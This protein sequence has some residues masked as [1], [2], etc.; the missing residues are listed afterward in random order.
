MVAFAGALGFAVA[1]AVVEIVDAH[2]VALT[3]C[4]SLWPRLPARCS[5][6]AWPERLAAW[7]V[8]QKLSEQNMRL[9]GA[10]NNMNQGLCMFDGENRLVVWNERYRTMYNIDPKHIWRGCGIRDLL[11]ARITAGTFPLDPATL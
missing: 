5:A 9:D 3:A 7:R 4:R 6:F 8:R 10:L 11:D 2:L 1:F